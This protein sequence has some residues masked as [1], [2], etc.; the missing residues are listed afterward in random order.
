VTTWPG[1]GGCTAVAPATSC[2]VTG[3]GP[4]TAVRFTVVA[5]NANGSSAPSAGTVVVVPGVCGVVPTGFSD[6]TLIAGSARRGA[7]CLFQRDITTNNPYNPAGSVTRAQMAAFMWRMA[8]SPSSPSSCGFSDEALIPLFARP[9][10]CW[11]KQ[12]GITTI[13]PYQPAG[14]VNRGQMAK[15]LWAFS[16]EPESAESC[17][18]ADEESIRVDFRPGACWLKATGITRNDPYKPADPVSRG[19]MAAFLYRTGGH[20]AQWISVEP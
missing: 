17:G 13:N 12:Q 3:L 9:G 15:F 4:S 7:S 8:G 10:T 5:T 11:L 2:V 14:I 20:N 16:G 19:Q 1:G 6:E 18:F